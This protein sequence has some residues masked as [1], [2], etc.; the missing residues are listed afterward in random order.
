MC[1]NNFVFK[2]YFLSNWFDFCLNGVT[3]TSDLQKRF[4]SFAQINSY[5]EDDI[6]HIQIL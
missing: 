6:L 1:I 5:Y 4:M 2:N 3:Q